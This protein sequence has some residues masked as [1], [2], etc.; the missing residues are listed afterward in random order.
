MTT[1][2]HVYQFKSINKNYGFKAFVGY[3]ISNCENI[4]LFHYNASTFS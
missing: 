4:N 3:P 1:K 2:F